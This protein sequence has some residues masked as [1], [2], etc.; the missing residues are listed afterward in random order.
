[1]A[2]RIWL[3]PP[4]VGAKTLLVA[5]V[6]SANHCRTVSSEKLG[7]VTVMGDDLALD[8]VEV[9]ATSLL[10]QATRAMLAA[11]PHQGIDRRPR[12]RS[13]RH[14]FLLSYATRI[15]ER[16][17]DTAE[18]AEDAAGTDLVPVFAQREQAVEQ[19]FGELFPSVARRSFSA[20]NAAGWGAG[21][22]AADRAVLRAERRALGR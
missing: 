3:D 13:F 2:R 16:L 6:G 17:R 11:G 14:A 12:T 22:D 21:R 5:E 1:M 19:L 9:L 10:V 15:G 7:F 4:Y 18:H 20:G 8:A